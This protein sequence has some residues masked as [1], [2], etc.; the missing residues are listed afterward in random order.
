MHTGVG[1]F[2]EKNVEKMRGCALASSGRNYLHC[3]KTLPQGPRTQKIGAGALKE[4][5]WLA[6]WVFL[7]G[8]THRG[9]PPPSICFLPL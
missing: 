1:S 4:A 7:D 9:I 3:K 2:E 6:G 8:S 5:G